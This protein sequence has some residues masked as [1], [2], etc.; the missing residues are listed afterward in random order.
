MQGSSLFYRLSASHGY[1]NKQGYCT[2]SNTLGRPSG[3]CHKFPVI[4]GETGTNFQACTSLDLCCD[5]HSKAVGGE[6]ECM[7]TSSSW[8]S[9]PA[10]HRSHLPAGG[11]KGASSMTMVPAGS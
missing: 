8:D 6:C 9:G 10:Q 5:D 2:G 4:I 11:C 7:R 1:L 3:T